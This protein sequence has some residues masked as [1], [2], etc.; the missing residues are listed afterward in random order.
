MTVML[1]F[2][3]GLNVGVQN[4]VVVKQ[5][6]PTIHTN[7][8]ISNH[9]IGAMKPAKVYASYKGCVLQILNTLDGILL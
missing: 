1:L 3:A 2:L 8:T 6:V 4:N 7:F 5:D 9:E